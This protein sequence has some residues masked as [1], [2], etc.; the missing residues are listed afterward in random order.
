LPFILIVWRVDTMIK[1][2]RCM[3][4]HILS[5]LP[6]MML[7]SNLLSP[8]VFYYWLDVFLRTIKKRKISPTPR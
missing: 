7:A 6:L 5:R 8:F 4:L 1:C 3:R 2:P